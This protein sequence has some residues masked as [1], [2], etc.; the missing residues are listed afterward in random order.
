MS[1][2]RRSE[3][4]N[5][6]LSVTQAIGRTAGT[7]SP[8]I[9]NYLGNFASMGEPFKGERGASLFARLNAGIVSGGQSGL[10]LLAAKN[11][12]ASRGKGSG[13]IYDW[14]MQK[15]EGLNDPE[16]LKEY[17]RIAKSMTGGDKRRA[18]LLLSRELGMKDQLKML[19]NAD[20]EM[21]SVFEK[22]DAGQFV[23]AQEDWKKAQSAYEAD[24][25]WRSKL[26]TISSEII[27]LNTME[28]AFSLKVKNIDD[29]LT[30]L[31][32]HIIGQKGT[33]LV[34]NEDV[35]NYHAHTN[36]SIIYTQKPAT[37]GEKQRMME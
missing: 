18:G 25:G 22:V 32:N 27:K 29:N 33:K 2:M 4:V 10:G 21:N 31:T 19:Y 35:S 1:G 6:V 13:D 3:F 7:V 30:N 34:S 24:L 14:E 8:E 23:E 36:S 15:L 16:M 9:A 5:Q 26:G 11:V 28:S 17:W 20:T 12:V 37:V